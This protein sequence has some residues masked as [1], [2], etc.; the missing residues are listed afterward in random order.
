MCI[1]DRFTTLTLSDMV[2]IVV[3]APP[4][5]SLRY[6]I[7]NGWS[8][9]D[10]LLANLTETQSGVAKLSGPYERPGI[11]DRSPGEQLFPADVMTW[12]EMDALDEKRDKGELKTGRAHSRVW[13]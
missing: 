8:R 3:G 2:S 6:F 7:D 11:G 5:S 13:R 9:T 12:A 4:S 10:H 1:R